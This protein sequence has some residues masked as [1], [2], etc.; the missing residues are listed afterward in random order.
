MELDKV[1]IIDLRDEQS[2][3]PPKSRIKPRNPKTV[4]GI[5]LHQTAV[6]Y[7]ITA[8]QIKASQGDRE[9]A[10]AR[11]ALNVACHALAFRP[12]MVAIT[13][14]VSTYVH[15]AN[16][17]NSHTLGLE[18]DG[19]YAGVEGDPKTVWGGKTTTEKTELTIASACVALRELVRMGREA[20]AAI[21]MLYAH[22]QAAADRRSDPGEWLWKEVALKYGRDVLG[23]QVLTDY[24]LDDGRPIP[25]AWDPSSPHPY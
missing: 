20:G 6:S 7:G 19:L 10:L 12:S 18:V 8:A 14:E 17:L 13:N 22:R 23:L 21:T 2:V 11:R 5:V 16:G 24:K 15:Q 25:N 4:T 1:R 3:P 9:M